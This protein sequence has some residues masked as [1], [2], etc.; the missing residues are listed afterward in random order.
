M[1]TVLFWLISED[2]GFGGPGSNQLAPQLPPPP[3]D[4]VVKSPET[5]E[6][7]LGKEQGGVETIFM[8][9][10]CGFR[11]EDRALSTP[12]LGSA[13]TRRSPPC[14]Q[15]VQSRCFHRATWALPVGLTRNTPS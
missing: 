7:K 15:H 5:Y 6:S 9:A 12:G 4:I 11:R 1:L 14:L 8:C 10:N 13:S 2:W 3:P